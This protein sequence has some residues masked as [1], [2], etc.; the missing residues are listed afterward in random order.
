MPRR[1]KESELPAPGNDAPAI[2]AR[3][4]T[5]RF[6]DFAAIAAALRAVW[7]VSLAV[8]AAHALDLSDAWWAAISAFVVPDDSLRASLVRGALRILG[9]LGGAAL[10]LLLGV[11]LAHIGLL[12]VVFMAAAAWAGLYLALTRRYGYAW[13]LG[14]VS[15]A[16]VMCEAWAM[17]G[18]LMHFALERCANVAV[19]TLACLAV[20]GVWALAR[21]QGA[22]VRPAAIPS[23]A[24][25]KSAAWHALQGAVAVGL[26]AAAMSLWSLQDFA[27]AMVTAL[28][29]LVVPIAAD[30]DPRSM[31]PQVQMR[32]AWRLA[33]CGLAALL[34][35]ALLPLLQGRPAACHLA[36][37]LGVAAG[38]WVQNVSS[39][40]R[41]PAI[42][43]TVAFLMIFVQDRGWTVQPQMAWARLA[44]IGAG[45]GLT[46][47]VM[48]GWKLGARRGRLASPRFCA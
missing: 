7:A 42:Q 18:E 38:A 8:A 2:R 30:A 1:P 33:G 28:A 48:A 45:A 22:P 40:L 6:G 15:F 3:G 14:V 23:P 10:G 20:E 19:G 46:L 11:H 24:W 13:V 39:R 41:Y 9:T 25:R 16:M 47:L 27:Q 36:L 17:R 32:M 5:K 34:A 43:F 44:G 29:V 35:L 37:A 31:H 12:F 4:V 21:R 26:V